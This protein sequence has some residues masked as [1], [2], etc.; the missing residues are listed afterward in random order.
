MNQNQKTLLQKEVSR[1]EFLGLAGVAVVS[2]LGFGP[3]LKLLTGKSLHNTPEAQ[4]GYGNSSY[5]GK[6]FEPHG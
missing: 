2:V 4:V 1:K 6:G 5:G 3:L